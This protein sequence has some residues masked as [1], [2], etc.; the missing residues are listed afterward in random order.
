MILPKEISSIHNARIY[1]LGQELQYLGFNVSDEELRELH[2]FCEKRFGVEVKAR[3]YLDILT[4]LPILDFVCS[5]HKWLQ[6][7]HLT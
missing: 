3:F 5:I 7:S 6:L 4:L 2:F 1:F